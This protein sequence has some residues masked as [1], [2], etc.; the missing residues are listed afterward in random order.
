MLTSIIIPVLNQREMTCECLTAIAQHTTAYELVLVDNGSDPAFEGAAIRNETNLGFPAAVNQGLAAAKGDVVVILNND[1]IVTQGWLD[2]LKAHLDSGWDMVGPITNS[3]S[4]PQQVLIDSYENQSGL[5]VAAWQNALKNDRQALPF[6]RLVFFCVSMRRAVYE[7]L[8]P[9]DEIY[10]PGN[11]EDDDYC[12]RAIEAGF[13][14]AIARDVFVHHFGGV[15][16]RA[17]DLDYQ[18]LMTK[19]KAKFDKKWPKEKYTELAEKGQA[20]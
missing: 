8:G 4:G 6:H 12:L 5:L 20:A 17:L 11:F 10:T 19:N 15:T 1:V 13:R 16:H 18:A 9:L 3:V 14:L 2:R 7:R